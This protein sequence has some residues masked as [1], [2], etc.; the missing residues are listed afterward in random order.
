MMLRITPAFASFPPCSIDFS[1]SFWA[2]SEITS[3]TIPRNNPNES[4]IIDKI[5]K[6]KPAIAFAFVLVFA[7]IGLSS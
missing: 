1:I 5:P 7:A 3:P 2:M 6:M 4:M